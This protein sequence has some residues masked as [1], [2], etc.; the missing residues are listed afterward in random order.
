MIKQLC[1]LLFCVLGSV[2]LTFAQG[3]IVDRVVATVGAN[4]ILQ[5]DID[6]QYSQNLAQGMSPNE[7]FKCYIL[8][9]LLTQKLLAQ[10]AVLDSI[11]VSE[12]EVDDNLNN[13]LNVM[14]RQAGGKERLE[15][16]LNRSLLQYKEEMRTSVAEQLKAQKMQ[17]NI[18]QKIDV[19]P[20]EVKRYFEGLNKDSLPYFDTE[21]EIGEIVMYPVLTKEEK[22]TSRKR[23]EDLRKQI[24][25]GSDFGTIAR[26]YSEDK[27]SAVAGG[28][29]GF[30]TRDNYVKE[31]SAVAFKLKP[32]EISQVFETEYGFHFLQVLERRGE[33]VRARHILVSI[34]PTNASLERTKVK[35][36][37]LYQKLINK[38]IDF[39]NAATQ[40]SDNKET[41]FNGGMVTDQNRSTLIPVNKLE[42]SVFTA[43]D[44][45]KAGEYSQ[46]TLFQEEGPSGKSGYRIS[47][48][49]TR[50]PPHKANLDQ[51]F[52]KIKEAASEDKTRRKLSE[53]FESRRTNTFIAIND[54]FHKCDDLK[55]WIKPIEN[56][57]ANITK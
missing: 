8:Q 14:T 32:G 20:L 15:S 44:P 11:E 40:Y 23:A 9:Q 5:S 53:W 18:V 33:E 47:F 19:T 42:A 38:K 6:M 28:D 12:S 36:D 52:S 39:Y 50:I 34:K 22:E 2:N 56:A 29:L 4:I 16:F 26:L 49:K 30:S 1:V 24:V 35:M 10:Q 43:I 25:D 46:P 27:G 48:L 54:D 3:K 57:S 37:S 7:D 41:K 13:R 31:F 55:I 45:L 17:Q 21:V 51:D